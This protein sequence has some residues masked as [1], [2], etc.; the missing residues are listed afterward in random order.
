MTRLLLDDKDPTTRTYFHEE[1]GEFFI[2]EHTPG[3]VNQAILDQNAEDRKE[4]NNPL[5]TGRHAARIP[6]QLRDAWRTDWE[7]NH[8]DKWKWGTFLTMKINNPDYKLLR[9]GV[10]HL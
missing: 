9:T 6:L 8:S 7:Q 3:F 5:A 10:N 4:G 1:G 2:H